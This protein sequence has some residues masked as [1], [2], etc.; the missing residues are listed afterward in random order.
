LDDAKVDHMK[1]EVHLNEDNGPQESVCSSGYGS[2]G[3]S[4]LALFSAN[5]DANSS[6][7]C[8]VSTEETPDH[9]GPTPDAIASLSEEVAPIAAAAAPSPSP[10]AAATVVRRSKNSADKIAALQPHR[11]S[12]P[13]AV[14]PSAADQVNLNSSFGGSVHSSSSNVSIER[15]T[16]T[17]DEVSSI[18]RIPLNK[19]ESICILFIQEIV[20]DVPSALK[21]SKPPPDWVVVG[22][23][24]LVRPYNWSGVVSFIGTTQFASGTWIGV[25]LDAATGKFSQYFCMQF[26]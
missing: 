15:L 22:E 5:E 21:A 20:A 14:L 4:M 8:S 12:Y 3:T 16:A 19:S 17:D 18:S 7:S 13:A 2:N 24:V 11:A 1:V 9:V 26:I 6:R 10:P 23:S 25:S